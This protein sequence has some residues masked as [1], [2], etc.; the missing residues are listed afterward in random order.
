MA[1]STTNNISIDGTTRNSELQ[2]IFAKVNHVY[3][4]SITAGGLN[5]TEISKGV[6]FDYEFPIIEDSINFNTGEA[7]VTEVKLIDGTVWTSMAT[8]GDSDINFNVATLD[9][10]IASQFLRNTD[11]KFQEGQDISEVKIGENNYV[12]LGYNLEVKKATGALMF[13]DDTE[14]VVVLL[15]NVEMY[16]TL[17]MGDGDNPAYFAVKVTPKMNLDGDA[18]LIFTKKNA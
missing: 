16:G 18:I 6:V 7:D 14:S 9:N 13:C 3:F 12:G 5:T 4:D 15:P 8:K 17:N 10:R 1:T 11:T 2:T